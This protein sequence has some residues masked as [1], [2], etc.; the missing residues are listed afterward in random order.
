[1]VLSNELF[2]VLFLIAHSCQKN[3]VHPQYVAIKVKINNS[4]ASIY[5]LKPTEQLF[6]GKVFHSPLLGF[7]NIFSAAVMPKAAADKAA[8]EY[9]KASDGS[10]T[11]S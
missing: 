2:M 8:T 7:L 10:L 9:T 6:F 11:A 4:I 3:G 5:S 1:M